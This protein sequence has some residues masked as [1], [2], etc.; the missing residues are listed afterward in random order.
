MDSI[1]SVNLLQ[2]FIKICYGIE[3]LENSFKKSY[4]NPEII[5][6]LSEIRAILSD[7][8]LQLFDLLAINENTPEFESL[9]VH[10]IYCLTPEELV[11]KLGLT[12]QYFDFINLNWN[13]FRYASM[14]L[15]GNLRNIR[16]KMIENSIDEIFISS[17]K[18]IEVE[19][20][21]LNDF[22]T[23]FCES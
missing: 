21:L 10:K 18:T 7:W 8:L 19:S 15:V 14:K 9:S 11:V 17:L 13:D 12:D 20:R 2:R 16:F 4:K 3:F 6:D 5:D 22:V 23:S 1:T